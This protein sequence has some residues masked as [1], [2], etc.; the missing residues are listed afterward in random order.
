MYD[1]NNPISSN[2]LTAYRECIK[3]DWI[4]MGQLVYYYGMDNSS[5]MRQGNNTDFVTGCTIVV[6]LSWF[7]NAL[8]LQWRNG[9]VYVCGQHRTT[10]RQTTTV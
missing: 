4:A 10:G 6:V 1:G 3:W 5:I 9:A 2:Y 7:I 8:E